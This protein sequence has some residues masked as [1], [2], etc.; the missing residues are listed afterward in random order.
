MIRRL[1][2]P[3]AL[4]C[5]LTGCNPIIP[6]ETIH[7]TSTIAWPPVISRADPMS[8]QRKPAEPPQT[9]GMIAR[10]GTNYAFPAQ[11]GR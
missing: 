6:D 7:L 1:A 2:G 10:S 11:L 8:P 4:S 3:I 9:S 5:L